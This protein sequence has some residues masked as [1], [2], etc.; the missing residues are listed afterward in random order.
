MENDL[1]R[2]WASLR[3][4]QKIVIAFLP[5]VALFLLGEMATRLYYFK[6]HR[7]DIAMLPIKTRGG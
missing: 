7:Y 3:F 6:L 1:T 5:V 2:W 4:I